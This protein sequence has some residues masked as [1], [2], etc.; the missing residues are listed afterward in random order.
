M[1]LWTVRTHKLDVC[2]VYVWFTCAD[3]LLSAEIS[4][5]EEMYAQSDIRRRATAD[6]R[7]QIHLPP[8]EHCTSLV[9]SEH[10]TKRK[11]MKG[12]SLLRLQVRRCCGG[13]FGEHCEP[14]PGPKGQPCFGNGVCLD[15]TNGTGVCQCNKG[16]NGTACET[17]QS[18][19]YGVHCDQGTFTS[20]TSHDITVPSCLTLLCCLCRL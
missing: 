15:G 18:G 8:G 2:D 20:F 10:R 11:I 16:F 1:Q 5:E 13:F 3:F 7:L 6:H 4:E 17:C 12:K 14:C 9:L 19:K